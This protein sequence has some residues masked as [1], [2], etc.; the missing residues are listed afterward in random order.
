MC[1]FTSTGWKR[2]LAWLVQ[3]MVSAAVDGKIMEVYPIYNA[4]S[5]HTHKMA[6]FSRFF[7]SR[8]I[9]FLWEVNSNQVYLAHA[10]ICSRLIVVALQV[11]FIHWLTSYICGTFLWPCN[12]AFFLCSDLNLIPKKRPKSE[13]IYF[14]SVDFKQRPQSTLKKANTFLTEETSL[15]VP[16]LCKVTVELFVLNCSFIPL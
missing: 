6:L 5:F 7:L 1:S 14:V 9:P 2:R 16:A 12:I 3:M 8:S 11:S 4:Q 15:A 13:K 10:K